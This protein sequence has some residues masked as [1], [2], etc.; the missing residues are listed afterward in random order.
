[1]CIRDRYK[2]GRIA[3]VTLPTGG[4]ISYTYTGGTNGIN[5]GDGT[6]MTITRATPDGTSTYQRSNVNSTAST[7]MV[8]DPAGNVSTLNFVI[9]NNN[10]YETQ[11]VLNQGASTLL[12]T[13]TR[14]YN[15][16]TFSSCGQAN[17]LSLPITQ[18]DVYSQWANLQ[19]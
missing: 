13:I 4:V 3:S 9:A 11:R 14:C 7:T 1:M 6:A 17:S 12:Q 18:L 19:N 5:C 15:Q 2:T 8:T 10:F 16:M